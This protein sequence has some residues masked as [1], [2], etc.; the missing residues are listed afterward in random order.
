MCGWG[1]SPWR[2]C[3][4]MQHTVAFLAEQLLTNCEKI[5]SPLKLSVFRN[6]P[7]NKAT[8][9]FPVASADRR[10]RLSRFII[11]TP[12]QGRVSE[13]ESRRDKRVYKRLAR[14]ERPSRVKPTVT[15]P[16]SGHVNVLH[17][18]KKT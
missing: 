7:A 16:I 4:E 14:S 10:N 6:R 12:C 3:S 1:S 5:S 11:R 13:V 9:L 18:Y 17:N 8:R 2:S 15:F